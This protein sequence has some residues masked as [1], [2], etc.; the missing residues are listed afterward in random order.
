MAQQVHLFKVLDGPYEGQWRGRV[1]DDNTNEHHEAVIPD[2][3]RDALDAAREAA[4]G[5]ADGSEKVQLQRHL[6]AIHNAH[7]AKITAEHQAWRAEKEAKEAEAAKAEAE[8]SLSE[9]RKRVK[10]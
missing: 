9:A 4:L 3:F 7:A 2:E 8:S 6:T 10:K 5:D 1:T